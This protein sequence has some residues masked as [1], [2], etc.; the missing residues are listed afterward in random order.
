MSDDKKSN[1]KS[2]LP[3]KLRVRSFFSYFKKHIRVRYTKFIKYFK[4]NDFKL[5]KDAVLKI[6]LDGFMF[7]CLAF[8]IG[9][10]FGFD[11]KILLLK[12]VP[13]FGFS[14]YILKKEIF[15]EFKQIISSINLIRLTK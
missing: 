11:D 15:S 2:I 12:L 1:Q 13:I 7:S 8:L 3:L 9:L 6:I 10:I 4:G 5:I 14:W